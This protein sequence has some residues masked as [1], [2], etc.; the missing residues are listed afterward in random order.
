[1]PRPRRKPHT[2]VSVQASGVY[3]PTIFARKFTKDYIGGFVREDEDEVELM[4]FPVD[5]DYPKR[6]KAGKRHG[7]ITIF[8]YNWFID[9]GVPR[10]RGHYKAEM[11]DDVLC[12]DLKERIE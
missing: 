8:I 4:L 1:M 10:Y 5:E 2:Y 6:A 12:V 7:G 11:I 3:I 9:A